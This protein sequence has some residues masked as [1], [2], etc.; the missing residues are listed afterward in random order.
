MRK[1]AVIGATLAL[2]AGSTAAMSIGSASAAP[3][4]GA[5][6]SVQVLHLISHQKSLQ[7][8]DIGKKGPSPGDQV[9]ETTIDFQHG[10]RVDRSVLNCVDITVNVTTRRFDA[11]CHGTF[12]FKDGQVEFGGETNFHTPFTVGVTG[13][14]GA[15]QNVGGQITVERTLPHSSTDVETLRLVFFETD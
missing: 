1:F 2:L 15:Y 13:G 5:T 14:S 6:S 7:V 4:S 11:L 3:K 8:I 12:V 9:I 10:T